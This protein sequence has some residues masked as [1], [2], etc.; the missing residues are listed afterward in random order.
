MIRRPPRSTLFPYTT[1]FRSDRAALG[2]ALG[3]HRRRHRRGD[4]DR[5][6]ATAGLVVVARRPGRKDPKSKRL[7]FSHAHISFGVFLLKKKITNTRPVLWAL[8]LDIRRA[9]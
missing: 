3:A 5:A 7:N 1:L 4:G 2:D 9:A 8:F 6:G